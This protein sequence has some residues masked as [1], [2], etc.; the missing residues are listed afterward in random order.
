MG[1]LEGDIAATQH[2]RRTKFIAINTNGYYHLV[3]ISPLFTPSPLVPHPV[4]QNF[5]A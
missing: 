4:F 1:E 5:A 2:S 3:N